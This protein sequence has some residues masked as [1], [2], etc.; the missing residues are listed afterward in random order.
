MADDLNRVRNATI[1]F[2]LP[3]SCQICLGKVKQ[4][5]VCPNQHVFC[6]SCL[7]IWLERN[8]QCPACRIEIT[9]DSPYRK[10]IGGLSNDNVESSNDSFSNA[11]V[12]R[13]RIELIARDYEEEIDR[14][15]SK[16]EHVENENQYLKLE[17]KRKPADGNMCNVELDTS[18]KNSN[19]V[20]ALNDKLK[21]AHEES[22]LQKK[23]ISKLMQRNQFLTDEN[24]NLSRENQ[25]IRMEV[26]SRSPMR[27]GRFTVAT[28]QTK[29]ETYEKQVKQLQKALERS[30][31]YVEQLQK[32]LQSSS[33]S[34]ETVNCSNVNKRRLSESEDITT[35]GNSA[36]KRL[37]D[38]TESQNQPDSN[39]VNKL[40]RKD[41]FAN[42]LLTHTDSSHGAPSVDLQA[43]CSHWQ[44]NQNVKSGYVSTDLVQTKTNLKAND[45]VNDVTTDRVR[46][47]INPR[48]RAPVENCYD[49]VSSTQK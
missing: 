14:L 17:L 3:I 23:K 16:L 31:T 39:S 44:N 13:A 46:T 11:A 18:V 40:S 49:N 28:L 35:S 9:N 6:E 4:P 36:K 15:Q 30:D 20:L 32:E 34:V 19:V 2:T 43:G 26:A 33:G 48:E 21:A 29:V 25:R 38:T 27:Y 12:R 5:V 41:N 1:A 24:I 10:V 37:F 45:K 47:G 22:E 8:N 42:G 7:K